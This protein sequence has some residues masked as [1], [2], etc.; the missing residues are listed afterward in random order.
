MIQFFKKN[1]QCEIFL[2]P[3]LQENDFKQV[4]YLL[5]SKEYLSWRIEFGRI[6]SINASFVNLLYFEIF[7]NMKKITLV[8]HKI[9]LNRYLHKL[10]FETHFVSLIK[11]DIVKAEQVKIVLIGGS[12]DSSQKILDIVKAIEFKNLT[13]VVVQHID[14]EL[15]NHFDTILSAYTNNRV[16][17]ASEGERVEEATVYLAPRDRHLKVEDGCFKLDNSEKYNFA[18]PSIS[19][20]YESFSN[21]Y[22]DS[23]VAIQECGYIKDGVD[24]LPLLKENATLTILQDPKECSATSMIEEAKRLHLRDFIFTLED[25]IDFIAFMDKKLDEKDWIDYLLEMIEK[26]Y[27]YDFKHYSSAM[28]ARRIKS[29]K[30]NHQLHYTKD[31]VGTI[32]FKRSAFKAFFLEL[33]INVTEL[34][35]NPKSFNHI[36]SCLLKSFRHTRSIKLWSAGCSSGKEAYSLAILLQNLGM[37]EKSIIY[38][39]DFNSV[40]LEEAKNAIYSLENYQLGIQ[41]FDALNLDDSLDNYVLKNDKFITIDDN[42]RKKIHFFEHNLVKDSSFNEFDIIICKNVIIYFDST[43]QKRV[44]DLFYASLKFGGYLVLGKSEAIHPY[45]ADKFEHCPDGCKIY[46][47]VN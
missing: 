47:K 34:F 41:N 9:K 40:V 30:I 19:L 6:Y 31:V 10:G 15:A 24:K 42:I 2:K 37:L 12:A 38:A 43:L 45:Y 28:V 8:T 44:F 11:D 5:N 26:R 39:T 3:P 29:F 7:K 25:M 20:S 13:L 46:K 22:K 27:A 21:Y 23:M 4:E 33:S 17:Y 14:A 1:Q 35:R 16:V 18:R 36:K 32:L